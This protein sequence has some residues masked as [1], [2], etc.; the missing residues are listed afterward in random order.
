MFR[1]CHYISVYLLELANA[2]K[3]FLSAWTSTTQ[4]DC[5]QKVSKVLG[6]NTQKQAT[7]GLNNSM[8]RTICLLKSYISL[9]N[10]F[11]IDFIDFLTCVRFPNAIQD[12]I[13]DY[14]DKNICND[15]NDN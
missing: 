5:E 11:T 6:L 1:L 8:I 13:H 14:Q 3:Y 9:L 7:E 2:N 15:P 10:K 12:N 4:M